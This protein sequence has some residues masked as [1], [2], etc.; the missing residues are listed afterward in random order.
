[1][2]PSLIDKI[3]GDRPVF[4]LG[5]NGFSGS[6][7]T[8]SL[9]ECGIDV[10]GYSRSPQPDYRFLPYT[11][12]N[13]GAHFEFIQLD[14][15]FQLDSLID[16]IV[17]FQPRVIANFAAQSMVGESWT[18]PEDWMQTNVIAMTSLVKAL[19]SFDF[20]EKYIH[21]TT[22]EVYG[23]TENWIPESFDFHPSTPYALSRATGDWMVKMW[24]ENFGLPAVFTRAANIYGEGQQLYRI[25]PKTLLFGM[26]NRKIPLHGGGC[27]VRSFIHMDDVSSALIKII[28]KG[29]VGATYHI[30]PEDSIS[31]V[32]LASQ[33]GRL[34]GIDPKKDLYYMSDDRIGKDQAYL[35]DS[36][37]IRKNLCWEQNIPLE[38]GLE[39]SLEWVERNLE[40]F[41]TLDATYHHKS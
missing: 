6:S 16:D 4:V 39:R 10:R 13:S 27:S 26:T 37:F 5:S 33:I 22:P 34:I 7:F 18:A 29:E 35:L 3:V 2:T 21:F 32:D 28:E 1:M 23:S 9:I 38:Y 15:N 8:K 20:L 36:T 25:I 17:K 40:Y 12:V 41:S 19:S 11:W 30:S 31:I 14:L 24:V